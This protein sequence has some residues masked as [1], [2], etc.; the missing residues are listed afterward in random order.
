MTCVMNRHCINELNIII[1]VQLPVKHFDQL[2]L[3]YKCCKK[4]KRAVGVQ[5]GRDNC[6]NG[7]TNQILSFFANFCTFCLIFSHVIE[8]AV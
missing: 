2:V 1:I 4:I 3:V 7:C 8:S 5:F 6:K